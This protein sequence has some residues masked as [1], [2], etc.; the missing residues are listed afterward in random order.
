MGLMMRRQRSACSD[1]KQ[2]QVNALRAEI[3]AP[4]G[5]RAAPGEGR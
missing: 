1:D 2:E 3:H 5:R 4:K